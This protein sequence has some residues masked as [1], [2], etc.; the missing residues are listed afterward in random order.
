[1]QRV[2]V[3]EVVTTHASYTADLITQSNFR[4][5]EEGSSISSSLSLY[6][7]FIPAGQLDLFQTSILQHNPQS[8]YSYVT[9]NVRHA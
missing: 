9:A 5:L 7:T 2:R 1:M 8:V 3:P 4:F 6:D